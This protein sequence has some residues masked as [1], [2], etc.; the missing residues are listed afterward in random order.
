LACSSPPK[1][2]VRW[3]LWPLEEKVVELNIV[4]RASDSTIGRA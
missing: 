4:E 2:R 1:G 3:S